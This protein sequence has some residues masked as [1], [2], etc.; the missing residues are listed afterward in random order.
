M[1]TF[2]TSL[3]LTQQQKSTL[4]SFPH[5][6]LFPRKLFPNFICF[7]T[8][9]KCL[10]IGF[11]KTL[12]SPLFIH[13]VHANFNNESGF[14]KKNKYFLN[15]KRLYFYE[16]VKWP[17]LIMCARDDTVP[18]GKG[19]RHTPTGSGDGKAGQ[20]RPLDQTRDHISL[21]APLFGALVSTS[22]TVSWLDH[23]GESIFIC[24]R[25][26]LYP[27]GKMLPYLTQ[28]HE[29]RRQS[30]YLIKVKRYFFPFSYSASLNF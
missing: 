17:H 1:P 19:K 23:S 10:K 3:C 20:S 18:T 11:Y 28:L 26:A 15:T 25:Q 24:L 13:K 30:S 4:L 12:F 14:I 7:L 6:G 9:V 27:S 22:H 2:F 8:L 21:F 29:I 5:T 16:S